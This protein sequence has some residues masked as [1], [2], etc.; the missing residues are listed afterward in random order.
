MSIHQLTILPSTTDCVP[1]QIQCVYVYAI[2][3]CIV[4]ILNLFEGTTGEWVNMWIC[5]SKWCAW[6]DRQQCD[7]SLYGK[8]SAL[9][10]NVLVDEWLGTLS[11][12]F[13]VLFDQ[14]TFTPLFPFHQNPTSIHPTYSGESALSFP[15]F[16]QNAIRFPN[17][18]YSDG[19]PPFHLWRYPNI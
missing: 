9:T 2:C 16:P 5:V 12:N 18:A 4:C 13:L 15:A 17:T 8:W 11:R 10:V 3:T 19:H 7:F 1:S 14:L 6:K